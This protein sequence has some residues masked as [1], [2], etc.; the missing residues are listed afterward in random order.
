M[1][2]D[3]QPYLESAIV[4]SGNMGVLV[5]SVAVA[6]SGNCVAASGVRSKC[7]DS[8]LVAVCRISSIFC[9]CLLFKALQLL[10][11]IAN[12]G[13]YGYCGALLVVMCFWHRRS[14]GKMAFC[15]VNSEG[16]TGLYLEKG[17]A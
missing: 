16:V 2:E 4:C 11:A 17:G 10:T 3:F 6:V 13:I 5:V 12:R 14:Y 9:K 15:S 8:L 1:K 7:A